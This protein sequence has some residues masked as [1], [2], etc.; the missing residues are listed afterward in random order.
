[1]K[2]Q[3]LAIIFV[4][5]ILPI[6]IALSAYTQFQ[7][8]TLNLQTTYDT[9]LTNATYDA[10][11][12]FQINTANSTMSDLTN[13]KMRD[14]EAS[15]NAFKESIKSTFNLSGYSEED[16]NNYIPALVYTMYD[17]F[18]IYSKYENTN[19]LGINN[20]GE[21][22]FGLKPYITYS[23][24][25]KTSRMDIT[26]TYSLDNYIVIQ[27]TVNGE[28]INKEGYL[29]DGISKSGRR[30]TYNGTVIENETLSE[31]VFGRGTC[32]YAKINGTKYYRDTKKQEIF[33]M[34]NGKDVVQVNGSHS[35]YGQ[36]VDKIENNYS[37]YKYYDE[38]YQ[39]VDEVKSILTQLRFS[40]AIDENGNKIWANDN[41]PI[42]T[43]N[44]SSN[45]KNNIENES[46][47][48]N[49]HRLAV[50]RHIIE[51]NLAIAIAN[52]NEYSPASSSGVDFQMPQ[53]SE[54]NWEQIIHN[55]A[56]ISFVQGL[57][58]GGKDYNGYAIVTNSESKEVVLE[59]NIYILTTDNQGNKSYCRIGDVNLENNSGWINGISAGRLNL[60]F[61]RQMITTDSGSAT[62]YYYPLK[63]YKASYNSIV[64]QNNVKTYDDIYEYILGT[65][66]N[67]KKAFYTALGRERYGQYKALRTNILQ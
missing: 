65:N 22:Q 66:E 45:Y 67:L 25:Y 30:I 56:L 46:S 44:N 48:F 20:D 12:A 49:Q 9:K 2:I 13:S 11:K 3:D 42:F 16:I 37:A 64:T 19:N 31:F 58:I 26:I 24:R 10:I 35:Q 43:F 14:I 29:I 23:C 7:I 39:F 50:I 60:D 28:Y 53:L 32:Q 27:G 52:F 4:I 34:S 41:R 21:A 62:Y 51:N 61:K 47:N 57:N 6:S 18:Y 33:Y 5:I 59:Q 36:Y 40:D 1:M 55:I 15:V 63:D 17:G 54:G 8:K 38:A